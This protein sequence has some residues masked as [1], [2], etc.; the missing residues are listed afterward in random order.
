L[1]K[2][3]S[4]SGK[5]VTVRLCEDPE[6]GLDIKLSSLLIG[7]IKVKCAVLWAY[8]LLRGVISLWS[9]SASMVYA[10]ALL[11]P[12]ISASL[13]LIEVEIPSG[14][15]RVSCLHKVVCLDACC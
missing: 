4:C 14:C 9:I 7:L 13:G 11:Y 8:C 6:R 5:N 3:N 1:L 15:L 12:F 10:G 2:D